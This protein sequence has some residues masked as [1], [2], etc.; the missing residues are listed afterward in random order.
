MEGR[1]R[2]KS[3]VLYPL[4]RR[5][6]EGEEKAAFT[7]MKLGDTRSW[8][9]TFEVASRTILS[10]KE[11]ACRVPEDRPVDERPPDR[12]PRAE[13]N[14]AIVKIRV[15]EPDLSDVEDR[16]TVIIRG[17]PAEEDVEDILR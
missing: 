15:R 4:L 5:I 16:L 9:R 13:G 11:V 2:S 12:I 14:S 3:A 17:H 7:A 10:V 8:R 6:P 1:G